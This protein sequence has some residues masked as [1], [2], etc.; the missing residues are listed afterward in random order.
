MGDEVEDLRE[1]AERCRR[2]A[3]VVEEERNRRQLLELADLLEKQA[4]K[5]EQERPTNDR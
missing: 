5:L 4:N 1:H 3:Q 2:L